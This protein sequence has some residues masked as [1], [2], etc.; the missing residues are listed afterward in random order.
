MPVLTEP[1]VQVSCRI[2]KALLEKV[3]S[4]GKPGT[5]VTA[6]MN[7]FLIVKHSEST[8]EDGTVI[9]GTDGSMILISHNKEKI[10]LTVT[11][12]GQSIVLDYDKEFTCHLIL[13]LNSL[14]NL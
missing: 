4:I 11:K 14:V 2:P 8:L 7:Q 9:T 5:V 6:T 13:K 1:T 10:L 3:K 12:N